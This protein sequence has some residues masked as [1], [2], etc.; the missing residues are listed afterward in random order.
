MPLEH[1]RGEVEFRDVRFAY[2]A[3]RPTLDGV[4]FAMAPGTRTALV[5]PSGSG[6]TTITNLIPRFYDVT[7]GAVFVDG[8]DV[9][10]LK[11]E[12]LRRPIALV[13]QDTILFSG[14]LGENLLYGQPQATAAQVEEACRNANAWD[15]IQ[16]LPEGLQ[17]E[18]GERG[19]QLSGGQKQRV[20]I[21]RAFLRDPRIL[22]LLDEAT[23]SLDSESERLIQDALDRLMAGRTTLVIAHRLSTVVSADRILVLQQGKIV[24]S[25]A[26]TS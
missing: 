11:V 2:A 5:G 25:G 4:S 13:L 15:F 9:R 21:A 7:G 14:T 22:I 18:V 20:T 10:T 16:A 24:D 8:H 12:S 19:T 23:S 1:C 26:T 3:H 6:K 17:T